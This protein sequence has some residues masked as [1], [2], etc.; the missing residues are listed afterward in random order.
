MIKMIINFKNRYIK[1][2]EFIYYPQLNYFHFYNNNIF[3]YTKRL[4]KYNMGNKDI[5]LRITKDKALHI[6]H[7]Y[8]QS[9]I[10]ILSNKQIYDNRIMYYAEIINNECIYNI[11]FAQYIKN[12]T[13]ELLIDD[14]WHSIYNLHEFNDINFHNIIITSEELRQVKAQFYNII[15]SRNLI[16]IL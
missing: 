14:M 1:K 12:K 5:Y 9:Y 6:N 7:L 16:N 2:S 3:L 13:R 4:I 15:K 8:Q 10:C 11:H